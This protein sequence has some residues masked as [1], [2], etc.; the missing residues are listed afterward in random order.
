MTAPGSDA[1]GFD[2][3]RKGMFC[4]KS[5]IDW[6]DPALR[7]LTRARVEANEGRAGRLGEAFGGW[8]SAAPLPGTFHEVYLASSEAHGEH[9]VRMP[10]QRSGFFNDLMRV[11]AAVA[12]LA[13]GR[14]IPVPW[15]KLLATQGPG[16]PCWC[17]VVERLPGVPLS[18]L[19]D[20]EA[21]T[22]ALLR[23]LVRWL[24]ELHAIGG[25]GF[26]PVSL[27]AIDASPTR[28]AVLAGLHRSWSDF[29][30]TRLDAHVTA[31]LDMAAIDHAEREL[32]LSLFSEAEPALGARDR[33]ALLHGDLGGH[34]L[35][36][37]DGRIVGLI[38]WED[39]LLGDPVFDF[40]DL[41]TFHPR[42]RHDIIL[43]ACGI[44][45]RAAELRLFWL[46]YLRIALA[47][48]VHRQRF[49]YRD[50][51]GREPAASRIQIALAHLAGIET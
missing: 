34:N 41:A 18:H 35:L 48:T 20:D 7:A 29:V 44:A 50:R 8:F 3:I 32:I 5:D 36:V 1:A 22:T 4:L 15:I 38:D 13:R 14:G 47:K 12:S 27:V 19:D 26:G 33:S 21:A 23:Y 43:S 39:S 40:A 6:P 31:C 46:Y 9:V 24:C 49:G 45:G 51:P 42:R 11:E 2:A 37:A 28:Q 25:D 30:L 10:V 17:H 16:E